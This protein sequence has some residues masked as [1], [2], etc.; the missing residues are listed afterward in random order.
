M[1]VYVD[2]RQDREFFHVYFGHPRRRRRARR[3]G[4]LLLYNSEG[5][6]FDTTGCADEGVGGVLLH[7]YL[8]R[9]E[10]DDKESKSTH[11]PKPMSTNFR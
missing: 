5:K 6:L 7:K 10:A 9:E 1:V 4:N 11:S 2:N 8:N 3:S